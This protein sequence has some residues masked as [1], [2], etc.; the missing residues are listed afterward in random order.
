MKEAWTNEVFYD[1]KHVIGTEVGDCVCIL[2]ESESTY[3]T[4]HVS[5]YDTDDAGSIEAGFDTLTEF[6]EY[7][8]I[9]SATF[10]V[11]AS[12]NT[13]TRFFNLILEFVWDLCPGSVGIIV[14]TTDYVDMYMQNH[15][16]VWTTF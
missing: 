2:F 9:N 15:S 10:I 4:F 6:V 8:A 7:G 12:K 14:N 3:G 1:D 5:P 13:N 11:A 16:L